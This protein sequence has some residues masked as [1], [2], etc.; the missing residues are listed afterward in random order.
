MEI[1][2]EMWA[3]AVASRKKRTMEPAPVATP[4]TLCTLY[5]AAAGSATLALSVATFLTQPRRDEHYA[6]PCV[7]LAIGLLL[8]TAAIASRG[9]LALGELEPGAKLLILGAAALSIEIAIRLLASKRF[10]GYISSFDFG[11]K[12][13]GEHNRAFTHEFNSFGHCFQGSLSILLVPA[14]EAVLPE[15]TRIVSCLVAVYPTYNL[16]KRALDASAFAASSFSNNS[17]E[18]ALGFW[19]GLSLGVLVAARAPAPPPA[20]EEPEIFL[21]RVAAGVLL[22]LVSLVTAVLYGVSWDNTGDRAQGEDA[23]DLAMLIVFLAVPLGLAAYAAYYA[24]SACCGLCLLCALCDSFDSDQTFNPES[25]SFWHKH[26]A[27]KR[28]L[29]AA[30]RRAGL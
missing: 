7:L 9:T 23:V 3:P 6:L 8:L 10:D 12:S 2:R 21:P 20:R 11:I 4:A 5:A 15:W 26:N 25:G 27:A 16:I 1:D 22:C 30:R 18:W 29:R 28:E 17:A 14:V 13:D 24:L 19:L